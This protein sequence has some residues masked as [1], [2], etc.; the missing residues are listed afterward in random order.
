MNCTI[1]KTG[2]TAPGRATVVL[3]RE[4]TVVVIRNVPAQICDDCGEYYLDSKTSEAVMELA[5]DAVRRGAEVE[6]LRYAA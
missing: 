6:V 5:E 4:E 3:E 1:C 2:K